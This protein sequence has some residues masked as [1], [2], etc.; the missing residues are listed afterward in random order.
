ME[1]PRF[2]HM[3]YCAWRQTRTVPGKPGAADAHQADY[4]LRAPPAPQ[5]R[6]G[7]RKHTTWSA[8]AAGCTGFHRLHLPDLHGCATPTRQSLGRKGGIV[9][10]PNNVGQVGT[11]PR[12]SCRKPSETVPPATPAAMPPDCSKRESW[13]CGTRAVGNLPLVMLPARCRATRILSPITLRSK[14]ELAPS[15]GFERRHTLAAPGRV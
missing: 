7:H 12:A 8:P 14:S 15:V 11:L 5:S 4:A 10:C 2:E 1:M 13:R 9:G 3:N 6:S